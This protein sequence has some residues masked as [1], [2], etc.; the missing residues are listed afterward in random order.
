MW[1]TWSIIQALEQHKYVPVL[2]QSKMRCMMAIFWQGIC[3]KRSTNLI[4]WDAVMSVVITT[5]NEPKSKTV[6]R[7]WGC[8]SASSCISVIPIIQNSD[9]N[10]NYIQSSVHKKPR[11]FSQ[12][13]ARL[14]KVKFWQLLSLPMLDI[15]LCLW[16]G[17]R[18]HTGCPCPYSHVFVKWINVHW[19]V[20][21][22]PSMSI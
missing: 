7:I 15:I 8:K 3:Q 9:E 22:A 10:C 6:N 21:N 19:L 1:G 2:Q 5:S 4:I 12:T 14:S 13:L 20:T 18:I 16:I 17:F 11:F